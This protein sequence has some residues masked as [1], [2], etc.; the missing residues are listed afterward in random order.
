[1]AVLDMLQWTWLTRINGSG[2]H[3]SLE[4]VK[5]H[6]WSGKYIGGNSQTLSQS[7]GGRRVKRIIV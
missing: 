1:M 7:D 3:A 6:Q 5:T 4:V 2:R